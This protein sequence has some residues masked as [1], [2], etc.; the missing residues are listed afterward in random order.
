MTR[1]AIIEILRSK[2]VDITKARVN[3]LHFLLKR[4]EKL[5]G[6]QEILK[7]PGKRFDR[8]TVYRTL[9]ILCDIGLVYKIFDQKHRPLYAVSTRLKTNGDQIQS[10]GKENC[11]FQ[12][13]VCNSVFYLPCSFQNIK[14]PGGLIKT[15]INLFVTGYC[16]KCSGDVKNISEKK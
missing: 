3:L 5:T 11:Y 8:T 12:C 9:I 6:L 10:S 4:D 7:I 13:E 2:S 16:P 1:N 14:L 15:G